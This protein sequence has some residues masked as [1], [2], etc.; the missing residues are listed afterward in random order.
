MD[1]KLFGMAF[2]AVFGIA[3]FVFGAANA[4]A[5]AVDNWLFPTAEFGDNTYIGTTDVSNMEVESA[6][7]MFAGQS[8]TW[9]ADAELHVTYQDATAVYPLEN[10][11]ILLDET[12]N[13]AETGSQNSFVFELPATTTQ[14]FLAQQF[15]VAAFSEA[16]IDIINQKLETALQD[17]QTK[18]SVTISDDTLGV[19]REKVSDVVFPSTVSSKDSSTVID[20]L[21][22]IQLAPGTRFSFLEFIGKLPLTDISDGEL[23]EIASAIYGAMLKTNFLVDER[24]I[25]SQVP[26]L[27]PVGQEAAI[28]RLLGIDF[29]FTNPNG[30]S[31][32]LNMSK[33]SDSVNAS[34]SGYP[35]LYTYAVGVAEETDIEPRLIK[36]YSAFVNSGNKV[37]EKG[38]SG[39][40]LNVIRTILDGDEALEVVTVSNDFYPP[41]NR[42]EVYPLTQPAAPEVQVPVAGEPGFVD[43]NGD[44]IH[45]GTAVTPMVPVAGQPGFV[46]AN[47]DGVHDSAAVLPTVPAA[48]QPGFVDVNGDG[49]HDGTTTTPTVPT[50]GQPGFI[51]ANGDGV[52]DVPATPTVPSEDVEEEKEKPVYD[53][54]GNLVTE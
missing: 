28:N 47:G 41:V 13:N 2:A 36:Q 43:A 45:D 46:D 23:T 21:D 50:V 44:G 17:G 49:V 30:S 42:V 33:D 53:K 54:G 27:I 8:E 4:G 29:A 48:G 7:M 34:L 18:T 32:T 24:S 11:E 10:A 14:A 9:R 39:K 20:A 31:F 40:R 51:D 6:K 15:P 38:R 35:F 37:A 26:A 5:Y 3:V 22:G 25:G 19:A 52:H 16:D 12:V 1:N